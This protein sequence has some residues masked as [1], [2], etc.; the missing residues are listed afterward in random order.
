MIHLVCDNC[1]MTLLDRTDE[2]AVMFSTGAGHLDPNGVPAPWTKLL[3][4]TNTTEDI[5]KEVVGVT[6]AVHKL[7]NFDDNLIE[8]VNFILLKTIIMKLIV[9]NSRFIHEL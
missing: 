3:T 4:F 5:A 9:L 7:R 2:L 8:K 6:E 1:T